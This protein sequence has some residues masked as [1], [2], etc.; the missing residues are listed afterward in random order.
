MS[1][2][3]KSLSNHEAVTELLSLMRE[4]GRKLEAMALSSMISSIDNIDRQYSELLST[5]QDQRQQLIRPPPTVRN[6]L[7]FRSLRPPRR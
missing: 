5:T 6:R 3:V 1:G 2:N 4:N 7:R